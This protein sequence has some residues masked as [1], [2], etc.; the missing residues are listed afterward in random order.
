MKSY[1]FSASVN[2]WARNEQEAREQAEELAS[3]TENSGG[4]FVAISD[5][6]PDVVDEEEES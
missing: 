3:L 4:A 2:V 6:A 5:D 1:Q